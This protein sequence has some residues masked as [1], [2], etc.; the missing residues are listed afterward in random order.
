MATRVQIDYDLLN[1]AKNQLVSLADGIKP[2][3]NESVFAHVV[4]N[5]QGGGGDK[6]GNDFHFR[7]QVQPDST[8]GL[9]NL[10]V[11]G[12]IRKLY[13]NTKS[14][15]GRA[16]DGLTELGHTFGSVGE[17][18][19]KFDIETAM[20]MTVTAA[21]YGLQN[22]L[23]EKADWDYKQANLAEC[24][25]GANPEGNPPEFCA[26]TDPGP[27]PLDREFVSD[28]G[29]VHTHLTL[30]ED[31]QTV[32]REHTTAEYDGQRY[33]TVTMYFNGGDRII[34]DTFY[35]DKSIYHSDVVLAGDGSGTMLAVDSTGDHNNFVRG[36]NDSDNAPREWV[37]V[38]G[39]DD[40]N[41]PKEG[42]NGSATTWKGWTGFSGGDGK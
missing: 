12:S 18:F 34:T 40:P 17:A 29:T 20:K 30:A 37:W 10:F 7:G 24:V 6:G 42:E 41:A 36:P 13:N 21:N 27:P 33:D 15:L 38:S 8:G 5:D 28:H 31:G 3:L 25:T 4:K 9:G 26:A 39:T 19:R 32:I 22:Y 16:H 35:P 1:D 11:E 14:T 23:S 2:L